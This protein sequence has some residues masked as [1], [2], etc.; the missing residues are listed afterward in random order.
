[1]TDGSADIVILGHF[2]MDEIEVDG[3]SHPSLGGAVYYGGIAG[4]HM[5][6]KITIITIKYESNPFPSRLYHHQEK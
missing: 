3:I 2:A 1:M 6:L 5:G 4:S